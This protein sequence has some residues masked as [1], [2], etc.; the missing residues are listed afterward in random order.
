MVDKRESGDISCTCAPVL[1]SD[2]LQ[3]GEN[4]FL[5]NFLLAYHKLFKLLDFPL[6]YIQ[7][8]MKNQ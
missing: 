1:Y 5:K 6:F 3:P 2:D 7:V 8:N 4:N